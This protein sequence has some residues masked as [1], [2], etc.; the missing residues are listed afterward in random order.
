MKASL[1]KASDIGLYQLIGK[2]IQIRH[3]KEYFVL[4][5]GEQI[6]VTR[7]TNEF[8]DVLVEFP[9]G[10]IAYKHVMFLKQFKKVGG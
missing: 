10:A 4:E 8:G 7:D 6:Y 2:S 5:R 1:N 9:N 3:I